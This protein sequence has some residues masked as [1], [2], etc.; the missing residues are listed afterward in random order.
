MEQSDAL[1]ALYTFRDSL[2]ECFDRRADALFELTDSILTAGVVPSPV[3]LSL[4][5]VHRRGW[6][7]LYAALSRGRIDA[8]S[9][10][11]LL[12]RHPL[13]E[14]E[15]PVYAVDVNVWSR[16]D[17]ESSP[18]LKAITTIR[19]ATRPANRMSRAGELQHAPSPAPVA[20]QQFSW[21][22]GRGTSAQD[23]LHL[24][25]NVSVFAP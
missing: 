5:A 6:G 18:L 21:S 10:R 19:H 23:V 24:R 12:N 2:Y 16:C 7:S 4:G 20:H 22:A 13:A 8:Q 11:A 3:H 1:D 14:G 25:G 9:L 17:A 15:S